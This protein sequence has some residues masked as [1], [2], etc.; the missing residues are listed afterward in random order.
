MEKLIQKLNELSV[1][2]LGCVATHCLCKI[3]EHIRSTESFPCSSSII[4]E[5]SEDTATLKFIPNESHNNGAHYEDIYYL[6]GY[7]A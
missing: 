1:E 7:K 5:I 6:M 3:Y 2:D 4:G